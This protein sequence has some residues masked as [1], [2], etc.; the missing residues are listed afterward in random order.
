MF[1]NPSIIIGAKTTNF[2]LET[3]R[4]VRQGPKERNYHVFYEILSSLDDKTKQV[5]H[6][7]NV[8]DYYY[9]PLWSSY[10]VVLLNSQ[11]DT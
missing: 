8:E 5:H 7:G 3:C 11:E 2:L 1:R 4:V 6:L 9:L 10:I